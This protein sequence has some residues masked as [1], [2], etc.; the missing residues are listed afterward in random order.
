MSR[1]KMTASLFAIGLLGFTACGHSNSAPSSDR[2]F[3]SVPA[4][5]DSGE[6]SHAARK[7]RQL[8]PEI[9]QD[10]Q[11]RVMR[12]QQLRMP[13]VSRIKALTEPQ[14]REVV[15]PSLARQLEDL[16]FDTADVAYFL[17][18]LDQTRAG[19]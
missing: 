6:W 4:S 2:L 19:R 18:D 3:A 17:S 1:F 7:T 16:G 15:R 14:Y 10:P 8:P 12:L 9:R 11:A 13:M 5:T